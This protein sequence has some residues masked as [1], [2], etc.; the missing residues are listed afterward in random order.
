MSKNIAPSIDKLRSADGTVIACERSGSGPNLVIVNGALSDR[1]SAAGLRSHLDPSFTVIAYDRRGRGESG[2]AEGY[3]PEREMDDLAAVLEAAGGRAFVFGQSSGAI[4]ALEAALRGL[5]VDRL[6]LNE[7]PFIVDDSRRPPSADL[8]KRLA[9]LVEAGDRE[10][11]VHLFL[12]DAAGL[13]DADVAGMRSTEAWPTMVSLAPTTA[14]DATLTAGNDLPPAARLAAFQTPTLVTC[15]S[16]SPPWIRRATKAL[17][18]ALP[19]GRLELLP[20]Q[21]HRPAPDVLAPALLEF[22]TG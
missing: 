14:Y 4:L 22:L 11:A 2:D 10:S 15:G 9:R 12:T 19:N 21:E 16:A 20:G 8:A 17:A 1:R 3:A 13:S 5:S 18:E 7:P 6:V